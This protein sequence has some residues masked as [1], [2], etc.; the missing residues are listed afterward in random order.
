[1][2]PVAFPVQ[3]AIG[4]RRYTRDYDILIDTLRGAKFTVVA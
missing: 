2:V 3:N 4:P 1:M